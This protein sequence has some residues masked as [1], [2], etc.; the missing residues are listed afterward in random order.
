[1]SLVAADAGVARPAL[2]PAPL[3]L[4]G[5]LRPAVLAVGAAGAL[6]VILRSL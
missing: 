3:L 4:V 6:L 1:M 5:G 2:M